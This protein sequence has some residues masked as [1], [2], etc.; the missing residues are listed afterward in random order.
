MGRE[1]RKEDEGSS[2]KKM[3]KTKIR[4]WDRRHCEFDDLV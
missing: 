3:R 4:V 1:K 2:R